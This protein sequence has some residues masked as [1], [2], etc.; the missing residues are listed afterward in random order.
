[1]KAIIQSITKQRNTRCFGSKT[2]ASVLLVF[3]L[4]LAGFSC[5]P[6]T[7]AGDGIDNSI[8][9]TASGPPLNL[10]LDAVQPKSMILLWSPPTYPGSKIGGVLLQDGELAYWVYYLKGEVGENLPTAEEIKDRATSSG[11][12]Q[13]VGTA[14]GTTRI[15]IRGLN[16]GARYFLAVETFNSF[17]SASTLSPEVIDIIMP[18]R[19][20]GDLTYTETEYELMVHDSATMI[21][22]DIEPTTSSETIAIVYSL[23][24]AEGDFPDTV[25]S[26]NAETGE[27]T[28]DPTVTGTAKFV[29]V[30]RADGYFSQEVSFTIRIIPR[31]A[32]AVTGLSIESTSIEDYSFEVQWIAPV[33]TGTRQDGRILETEEL[34]Y[35]VYYLSGN[36]DDAKPE[37]EALVQD[38]RTRSQIEQ[39]Q[40]TMNVRLFGLNSNTRYFVAVETYN[41]FTDV[42]T[43][44]EDVV[45]ETTTMSGMDLSGML[46]YDQTEYSYPVSS[47]IAMITPSDTPTVTGG[48][49]V[50][51]GLSRRSGVQ[52]SMSTVT[53]DTSTG[54]ITVN[55]S[56]A[57]IAGA[58]SYRVFA[59]MMG[60]NT[61]YAEITIRI[62]Q[63]EFT[64]T[65]YYSQDAGAVVPV[66]V[67]Q[68]LWDRSLTDD[69]AV[70]S[71]ESSGLNSEP[72]NN[73]YMV[74]I[75]TGSG[76]GNS[77]G[78]SFAKTSNS[79]RIVIEKSELRDTG[80]SRSSGTLIGLS[81][82][83]IAG[84]QEVAIYRPREIRGWQDLQSMRVNL[85][86][87]YV[88][89]NDIVFPD[90]TE[91]TSN[92][93]SVAGSNNHDF[94]NGSLHGTN[95][96]GSF[97]IVG[98]RIE[99]TDDYQGLFGKIT[100]WSEG[101]VAVQDI[102]FVDCVV[103]G[104][105]RVGT[106]AGQ[107]TASTIKNV[108]VEL[109][110][111]GVGRV[112]GIP[113][114]D[115]EGELP[116]G[117]YIGGLVGQS[118]RS[119]IEGYV[120]VLVK[121][122]LDVGGLVGFSAGENVTIAGHTTGNVTGSW[123]VGG[124]VG[125]TWYSIS[126]ENVIGYSTG[127]ITGDDNV[128]GLVGYT[129]IDGN[130][131]GYSTGSITGHTHVGGLVGYSMVAGTISG[132]S[133]GNITGTDGVGGLLGGINDAAVIGYSRSNIYR[134]GTLGTFGRILG[135]TCTSAEIMENVQKRTYHSQGNPRESQ[136]L[137]VDG[138]AID[139]TIGVDGNP[140]DIAGMND[141]RL[142]SELF[143]LDLSRD[144]VWMGSGKWPAL[145]L[146]DIISAA[147][148]PI[149]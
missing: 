44:S 20:N 130:I 120:D 91:G 15:Q 129:F 42:S 110:A 145:D 70:L 26:I 32:G 125:A 17:A 2:V 49:P 25:F 136:L 73:E 68:G 102:V 16:E 4:V 54:T 131:K 81:G 106:V 87:H 140:V 76:I 78:V 84:V 7:G 94:F 29:V 69:D 21:V 128:G 39:V 86:G 146:G 61:Q 117:S 71:I 62:D 13:R 36:A 37:A 132:Y 104:Q 138:T 19:F 99:S 139:G 149:N 115:I 55:P 82:P 11:A 50:M 108:G 119:N 23:E 135:E 93:E 83:G 53:I 6:A 113:G 109:G 123:T 147:S 27:I 30:A 51:Y 24:K 112:E 18:I 90:T 95:G 111:S 35:R 126:D 101:V 28:I 89:K 141:I 144:W 52:F 58:A 22:P 8:E 65:P 96:S 10:S 34:M 85:D 75:D 116:T 143:T 9:P 88:L 5:A 133:T 103:T 41:A 46:T 92:F 12:A 33:E 97:R 142:F 127:D 66:P 122:V 80:M 64:I 3:A 63:I 57:M 107:V 98:M 74:H 38:A 105:D 40:G 45:D 14:P 59:Q 47:P 114:T 31:V 56:S 1:M 148:Q 137:N 124:L 118:Y 43:L 79:N 48:A 60:F 100:S 134:E 77:R 67:G 121:G 72:G